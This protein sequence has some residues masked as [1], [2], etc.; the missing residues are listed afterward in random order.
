MRMENIIN[1]YV[2][3]SSF[4]SLWV[5]LINIFIVIRLYCNIEI[6]IKI[7]TCTFV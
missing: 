4:N 6:S 1:I 2:N 5:F 7:H 3:L